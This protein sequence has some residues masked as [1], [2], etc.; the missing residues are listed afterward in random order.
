[1]RRQLLLPLLFFLENI[2][3]CG[4]GPISR[5]TAG[6]HRKGCFLEDQGRVLSFIL[7]IGF[8]LV[9]VEAFKNPLFKRNNH[10]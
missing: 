7:S 5:D 9:S 3:E 4:V 6:I 2:L 10:S 8:I 1:M